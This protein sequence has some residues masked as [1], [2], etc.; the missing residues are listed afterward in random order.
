AHQRRGGVLWPI[1]LRVAPGLVVGALLGAQVAHALSGDVLKR[2]VGVGA[3]LVSLQMGLGLKPSSAVQSAR[4]ADLELIGAGTVIGLLSSLIGIG[5][6]S[7]TVP[8]LT[9]RG[10]DIRRAVGTSAACGMPIA[11]GG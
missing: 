1:F 7:L 6:G 8:Y 3:L 11:W 9:L 5:G 4:P 10:I 2:V